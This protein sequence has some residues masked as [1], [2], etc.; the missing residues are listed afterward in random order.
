MTGNE[1]GGCGRR[2]IIIHGHFYQPPRENAWLNIVERQPSADPY[3]DWN[4]RVYDQCYRP[5]AYS[6]LLDSK[7][8]IAAIHNNYANLNFNFGP[9]LFSWL[10]RR[11]PETVRRILEGDRE[12]RA[13]LQNHGNAIGQVY[14]HCIMPLASRRDQITQIRWAKAFFRKHF[15]RDPE[16]LWLAETAINMETVRCLVEEGIRFVVL[17]PA[18]AE[19]FRPLS[20]DTEWTSVAQRGIDTRRPYRVFPCEPGGGRL[21]GHLDVFFFNEPLSREVSFGNLLSEAHLFGEKIRSCFNDASREDEAVIIATDGETFGHHKP[22]SDMCLAYF[23]RKVAPRMNITPVNFAWYLEMHPPLHEVVLK[24]AFSEGSAWSCAHGVGRWTRDCGCKTG[25][26]PGW[27]Q[28]WRA[29]LREA[30]GELQHRIDKQ[31]ER[32]LSSL[33][34]DPWKVRDAYIEIDEARSFDAMKQILERQGAR[35]PLSKEQALLAR[36]LI[37]AQKF[38]LFAYTS[39][40]WFFSDLSGIETIQN[41]A[42]AGRAMQLGIDANAFEETLGVFLGALDRVHGNIA[43]M[44]GKTIFQRHVAPNFRHHAMIAFTAV[45]EKI[46]LNDEKPRSLSFDSYGYGMVLSYKESIHNAKD[47]KYTVYSLSMQRSNYSEQA[48]L[49]VVLHQNTEAEITG[50]VAPADVVNSPLFRI[51]DLQCWLTH[52]L[53]MK[54][55]FSTIFEESKALLVCHFLELF[56]KDTL[57]RYTAWMDRNEKIITSLCGLNVSIPDYVVAPVAYLMSDEWNTAVNELEVYGREDAVF[58]RL[59]TMWKKVEKY[60]VTIDFTK[61]TLLLEQ[62]LSAELTLF[63]AT[64]SVATSR[65]MQYLL[66]IVDRFKIPVAKNKLEEAFYSILAGPISGLY[67]NYKKSPAPSPQDREEIIGLLNFARRMNFNTDEF[68]MS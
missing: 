60:N 27:K 17:S 33:F 41:I 57:H 49:Y 12:S 31:Y 46:L 63:A 30:F 28:T 16:G 13:A 53:V 39:C 32:D 38:M 10:L 67:D 56:S 8:M 9:T 26:A 34:S 19:R 3:H 44:T 47:T 64:L 61:S 37:E 24:N 23:F 1:R 5:N 58:S 14:N 7:G 52:P 4:E 22:L 68:P 48:V 15:E 50:M 65:R 59:L 66:N 20:G 18:Q 42:Y 36:R 51:G 62:L 35:D 43:G 11:H 21:D 29:P 55:D 6:R 45:V 54:M 2:Y 25:G 40:G